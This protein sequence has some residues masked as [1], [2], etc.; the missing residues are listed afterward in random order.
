MATMLD[1][2]LGYFEAHKDELVEHYEG[3]FVLIKDNELIQAFST[4]KE[5]YEA[6]IARFGNEPFLIKRVVREDEPVAHYPALSLGVL[7]A[8]S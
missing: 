3:Q 1:D 4:E 8:G 6:G 2:E 7:N 5:A